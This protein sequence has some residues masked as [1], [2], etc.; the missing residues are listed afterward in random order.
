MPAPASGRAELT[1]NADTEVSADFAAIPQRTLTVAK[2]G[3]GTGS[4]SSEP[5]GSSCGSACSAEYNVG[6]Q[7][8]LEATADVHSTF[9]GWT[10]AGSPGACPGTGPCQLTLNADAEVS[11]DFAAIPQRTLTVAKTSPGKGVLSTTPAGLDCEAACLGR[12]TPPNS[13]SAKRSP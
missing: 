6:E 9:T 2:T 10:V 5:A 11:A 4:V 13:T 3:T 7:V 1:L 8:R 12:G